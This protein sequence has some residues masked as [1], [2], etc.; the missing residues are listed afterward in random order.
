ML[1]IFERSRDEV[2]LLQVDQTTKCYHIRRW[3]KASGAWLGFRYKQ[4]GMNFFRLE[5][6]DNIVLRQAWR[7]VR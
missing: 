7:N 3:R 4:F 2:C 1:F 5:N 6:L